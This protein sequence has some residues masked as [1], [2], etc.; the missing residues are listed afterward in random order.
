MSSDTADSVGVSSKLV[1][2]LLQQCAAVR[3]RRGAHDVCK[4]PSV[5]PMSSRLLCPV[6]FGL[7]IMLLALQRGRQ[8]PTGTV[9]DCTKVLFEILI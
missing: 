4:V 6:S 2:N 7:V 3:S 5:T 1:S 9:T 8:G